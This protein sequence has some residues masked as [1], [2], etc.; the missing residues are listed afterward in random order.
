[1]E[2]EILNILKFDLVISTTKH[3]LQYFLDKIKKKLLRYNIS[4]NQLND[5][6]H[7]SHVNI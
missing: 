5:F 6:D 2:M 3:F 1:M 4:K 7:I